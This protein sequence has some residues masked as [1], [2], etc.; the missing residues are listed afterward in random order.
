MDACDCEA[1]AAAAA[2]VEGTVCGEE[3]SDDGSE[4]EG[5]RAATLAGIPL[6]YVAIWG[7]VL[8]IRPITKKIESVFFFWEK[9]HVIEVGDFPSLAES[10]SIPNNLATSG[11]N[12]PGCVCP[13]CSSLTSADLRFFE[14]LRVYFARM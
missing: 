2:I 11:G 3:E 10:L 5:R 4:V 12:S 13:D 1:T 7:S 14:D 8:I 6:K 9:T